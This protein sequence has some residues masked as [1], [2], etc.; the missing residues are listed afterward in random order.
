M[1]GRTLLTVGIDDLVRELERLP[2]DAFAD[3]ATEVVLGHALAPRSLEPYAFFS[4]R[5]YT[6]NLIFKNDVFE[7]LALCWEPGQ[8]SSIHDHRDQQ[9]WMLMGEGE[10]ENQNY[11][12]HDR[13]EA[14][15]TCRLEATSALRITRGA[16]MGV[17]PDEPVHQ[18]RN[19]EAW[20]RR[21]LSVHLYSRPF[22]TCE[23]YCPERG[24]Y[25][26]VQLSYFSQH[27]QMCAPAG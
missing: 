1:P 16:P 21:A 25:M 7:L 13:D 20:G 2:A 24:I 11:R 9:C 6:R 5:H 10:L 3:A 4:A 8:K 26:D 22:D 12:V 17:D 18:I 23:T 27:G 19:L 15:R 14:R